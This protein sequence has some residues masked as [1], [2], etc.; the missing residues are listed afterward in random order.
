MPYLVLAEPV[1]QGIVL[2]VDQTTGCLVTLTVTYA[3][4]GFEPA[5]ALAGFGFALTSWTRVRHNSA[6]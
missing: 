1:P 2:T 5:E 4:A 3:A 6:A